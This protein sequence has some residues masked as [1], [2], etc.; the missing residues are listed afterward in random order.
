MQPKYKGY[1]CAIM[2]TVLTVPPTHQTQN[3]HLGLV[4][5]GAFSLDI[6]L[7]LDP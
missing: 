6:R 2:V 5:E 1:F 7:V 4:I 3:N